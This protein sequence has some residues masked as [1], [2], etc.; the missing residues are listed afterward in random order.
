MDIAEIFSKV[1]T[2]TN[3]MKQIREKSIAFKEFKLMN[4]H[5]T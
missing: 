4:K 3:K 5:H 2:H 1:V